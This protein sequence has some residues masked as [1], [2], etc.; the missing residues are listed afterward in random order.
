MSWPTGRIAGIIHWRCYVDGSRRFSHRSALLWTTAAML[1]YT[2]G[3]ARL[4]AKHAS[5]MAREPQSNNWR[6]SE[7]PCGHPAG[8]REK[9]DTRAGN[10]VSIRMKDV[11]RSRINPATRIHYDPDEARW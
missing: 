9:V 3:G 11:H 1:S 10:A 6:Q 4:C 2:W 5:R 7:S 8:D